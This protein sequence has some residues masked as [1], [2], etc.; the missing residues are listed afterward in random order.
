MGSDAYMFFTRCHRLYIEGVRRAVQ[1]CLV[2]T[3]GE[4]WWE[5]GVEHAFTA[6]QCD[7]L[8]TEMERNPDRDRSLLLDATHFTRIISKHHNEIFSDAFPDMV[9]TFR[10]MRSLVALRNEWAHVQ[11]ISC[12]DLARDL[13]LDSHHLLD[14]D[15]E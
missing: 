6:E 14:R 2:S 10:E 11:E 9:K 15:Q 8:R 12:V 7:S 13:E 4:E 1:E 5:R 3:L